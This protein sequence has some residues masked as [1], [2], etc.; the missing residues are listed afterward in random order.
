[1]GIFLGGYETTI[2]EVFFEACI[3]R[4]SSCKLLGSVLGFVCIW[5]CLCLCSCR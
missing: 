1:M 5:A 4:L 3:F 2:Y